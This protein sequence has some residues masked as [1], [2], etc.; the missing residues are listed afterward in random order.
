MPSRLGR[1]YILLAWALLVLPGETLWA[2][3]PPPVAVAPVVYL[4]VTYEAPPWGIDVGIPQNG[5]I[6]EARDARTNALLWRKV[7]YQIH[8]DPKM[9]GDVQDVFVT[10]LRIQG[11]DLIVANE[12]G[13][14]FAVDLSNHGVRELT[15]TPP[16]SRGAKST[17][18]YSKD[19]DVQALSQTEC[20]AFGPIAESGKR[21]DGEA[22]LA[23]ILKRDDVIIPLIYVYNEGTPEARVYA[24]AAFHCLAPQLFAQCRKDLVGGY[25]P[26]VHSMAG[27]VAHEGNLLE[28]LIRIQDGEYD[29]CIRKYSEEIEDPN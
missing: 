28:F 29:S 2:K 23:R 11:H 14:E 17:I 13:R 19:R 18:D 24:L 6:V 12:R 4:G 16:A 21:V 25:N 22:T 15:N 9:E 10:S 1:I 3:R 8:F 27:C 5:G 26:I 20:F 7:V